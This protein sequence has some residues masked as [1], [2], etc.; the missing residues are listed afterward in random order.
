MRF[1]S[2]MQEKENSENMLRT[3]LNKLK[4]EI[5]KISGMTSGGKA[6]K[7]PR[8]RRESE[9]YDIAELMTSLDMVAKDLQGQHDRTRSV[10]ECL[11]KDGGKDGRRDRARQTN[12]TRVHK[13]IN[14][15]EYID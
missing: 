4:K 6:S 10:G 7:K 15:I 12:N 11:V 9:M 14:N 13:K 2:A 5:Q 3:D 1:N 8:Y